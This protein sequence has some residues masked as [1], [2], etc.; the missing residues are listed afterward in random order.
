[1]LILQQ[2]AN[3]TEEEEEE[4]CMSSTSILV[5]IETYMRRVD[6]PSSH[7]LVSLL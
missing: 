2:E 4:K 5:Y 7:I 1:M 3:V 6:P